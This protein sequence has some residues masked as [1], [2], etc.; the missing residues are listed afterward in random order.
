MNNARLICHLDEGSIL[1]GSY[2]CLAQ[3]IPNN[4]WMVSI[5]SIALGTILDIDA[6]HIAR[7]GTDPEHLTETKTPVAVALYVSDN[8]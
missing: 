8:F 6:R 3:D 4:T 2:V 1:V 5:R 7:I